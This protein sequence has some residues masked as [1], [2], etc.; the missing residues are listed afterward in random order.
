MA[1]IF[2]NPDSYLRLVTIQFSSPRIR[3]VRK[4]SSFNFVSTWNNYITPLSLLSSQKKFPISIGVAIMRRIQSID[5]G[6]VYI[7]LVISVIPILIIYVF[8]SKY[9]LGEITTGAVK[10]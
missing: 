3:Q 2:P 1:G 7:T 4:K 10:G 5:L 6:G 9:T 8:C